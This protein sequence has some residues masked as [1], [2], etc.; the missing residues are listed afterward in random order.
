MK[1]PLLLD[2]HRPRDPVAFDSEGTL[3]R[4][5]LLADAATLSRALPE[6]SP[7]SRILLVF[8]SDRYLCS[9][10]LF[11][12]WSKGYTALIPPDH[13]RATLVRLRERAE[14]GLVLHDTNAGVSH[15]VQ[16]LLAGE[17]AS[18]DPG[19]LSTV[20]E[21]LDSDRGAVELYQSGPEGGST[22]FGCSG[23]D[24]QRE[25][26]ALASGPGLPPGRLAS[27]VPLGHR[28]GLVLGVLAPLASGGAFLRAMAPPPAT[29][30][31]TMRALDIQTL[32]SV[33]HHLRSL[34]RDALADRRLI[35]GT[36]PWPRGLAPQGHR[37]QS[38]E[39]LDLFVRTREGVLAWRRGGSQEA[40]RPLSRRTLEAGPDGRLR[41]DAA[42][43]RDRVSFT[44]DG[45]FQ[46]LGRVDDELGPT[47]ARLNL[48]ALETKLRAQLGVQDAAA[49]LLRL[50]ERAAPV[51]LVS[52]ARPGLATGEL[53][54][55]VSAELGACP[56]PF[57]TVALR[58]LP[59]DGIGRVS[60]SELYV[61]LGRGPDG[62]TRRFEL[63]L[64]PP[65][66]D[67]DG[68]LHVELD[69]PMDYRWF[70]GHF[71]GYPVL[72][73]AVQL[74]AIVLPAIERAG[75]GGGALRRAER[76]KFSGRIQP[77][78]HVSV[79]LR[80]AAAGAV[81]FWLRG[82]KGEVLTAGRLH[83]AAE[84]S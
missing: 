54:T 75:L 57:L 13:R 67:E 42:E 84:L 81:D 64:S 8:E 15:R 60:I 66:T 33:P 21:A 43:T 77:G 65:R 29:L 45:L 4:E 16:A 17:R 48:R 46:H 58:E 18:P 6:L 26:E 56:V 71:E 70:D 41:V 24:L 61:E 73:A 28:F 69:V 27:T 80:P 25:L 49:C 50:P 31:E 23:R 79:L 72:P 36:A 55:W 7:G 40:W 82:K 5:T 63:S 39:D 38:S 14:R 34:P 53:E 1:V 37:A 74:Q 44:D 9:A 47:E 3:S 83:F 10:A 2:A 19:F 59:R 20:R 51:L 78:D 35:V 11:A 52:A 76:L 62:R 32:V 22:S 30:D 12:V 68:A